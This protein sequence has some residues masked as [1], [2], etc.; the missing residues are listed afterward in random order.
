MSARGEKVMSI[1]LAAALS[2]L[3]TGAGAW[4]VFGSEAITREEME[5]Y[6]DTHAV[7]AKVES[8]ASAIGKNA[9][10]LGA[11]LKD[12]HELVTEQRVL[13]QRFDDYLDR[14]EDG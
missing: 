3:A 5:K 14:H 9:A 6:V 8:N 4:F 10:Q 13:I 7:M 2:M 1:C 11:L 12:Q